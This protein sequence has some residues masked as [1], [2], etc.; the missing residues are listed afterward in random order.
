MAGDDHPMAQQH[1]YQLN[2]LEDRVSSLESQVADLSEFKS[3]SKA[4]L[5]VIFKT[6][7]ELKQLLR[8]YTTEMKG[9]MATLSN[10]LSIRLGQVEQDVR[11]IGGKAGEKAV[12]RWD[13]VLN[14]VIKFGIV[15]LLGWF[16]AGGKQ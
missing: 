7:D 12:A 8:E 9:A 6:L 1:E 14:D 3:S 5:D 2:S 16:I 10:Q 15:G 13:N 4:Q 11:N